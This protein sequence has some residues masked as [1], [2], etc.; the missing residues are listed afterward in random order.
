MQSFTHFGKIDTIDVINT[1]LV[2]F[3]IYIF[4]KLEYNYA[5]GSTF[6]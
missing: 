4:V 2:S 5:M 6:T 3:T 1:F